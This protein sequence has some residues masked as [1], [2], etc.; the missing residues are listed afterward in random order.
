[1]DVFRVASPGFFTYDTNATGD[2]M[3]ALIA[4]GIDVVLGE[5]GYYYEDLGGGQKG[6][7]I[8]ADFTGLTGVFSNPITSVPAYHADGTPKL[9]ADGTPVMVKGMIEMGGFDFSKT[10]N[11]LYVLGILNQFGGDTARAEEYLRTLW[12]EDYDVQAEEYQ[13]SDVFAGRYHGRGQDYTPQIQGYL[14]HIITTGPAERHGC[15]AV[16]EELAEILQL[17]MDKY[18][19]SGVDHSWTKLCYYY[20]H[21][22]P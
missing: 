22:G 2:M 17:L 18:T 14:D 8:Y 19:F 1:M 4:G 21:I 11:D 12:G 16:T 3:Y 5:D 13:L 20:D 6:S 9:N 7:L 15:V 10:E